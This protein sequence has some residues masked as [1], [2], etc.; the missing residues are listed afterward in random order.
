VDSASN[1]I[2]EETIHLASS[3]DMA[4]QQASSSVSANKIDDHVFDDV[5]ECWCSLATK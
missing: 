5:E 3:I 1:R 2:K 4:Q